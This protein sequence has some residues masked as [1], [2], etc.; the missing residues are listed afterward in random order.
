MAHF[1]DRQ[2]ARNLISWGDIVLRRHDSRWV[3]KISRPI[4]VSNRRLCPLG[5]IFG[6]RDAG[7]ELL[8]LT[9]AE[10]AE[11]GFVS[12]QGVQTSHL[13]DVWNEFVALR[14]EHAE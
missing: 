10:A 5:Q 2:V 13:N 8:G 12:R 3:D 14:S 7:L 11:C 6:T 1:T 4:D 9:E